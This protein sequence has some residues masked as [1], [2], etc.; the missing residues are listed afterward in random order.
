M[1]NLSWS[2]EREQ[3]N[4]CAALNASLDIIVFVSLSHSMSNLCLTF[5]VSVPKRKRRLSSEHQY[6]SREMGQLPTLF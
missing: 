5:Y 3:D 4:V 2:V 6:R 1:V